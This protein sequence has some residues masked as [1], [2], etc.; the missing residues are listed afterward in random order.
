[1]MINSAQPTPYPGLRPFKETEALLFFGQDMALAELRERLYERKFVAILGLSGCGKSSL[2]RAGLLADIRPKK[3]EGSCSRWLIGEMQPGHDPL[4]NLI[5]TIAD[6]QRQIEAQTD[7]LVDSAGDQT[8]ALVGAQYRTSNRRRPL[9]GAASA[10]MFDIS[11]LCAD[12]YG[13]VRFGSQASLLRN[14]RVL[15]VVDQFEELFRFQREA[16]THQDKDRAALF[17]RLLIEAVRNPNSPVSVVIT[18]RS[19]FLGDC[20]LFFGLA[21]LVNEGTFL[22]PRISRGQ[23]EEVI[24]GP[25]EEC[26]FTVNP[27][28]I[29]IM[30]NEAEQQEDGLPLL[31]HALHRVWSRKRRDKSKISLKDFTYFDP[32]KPEEVPHIKHHL[33]DHL[34]RIYRSLGADRKDV[35]KLLFRMLYKYDKSGRL[36]RRPV[37]FPDIVKAIGKGREKDIIAVIE[38]FR[39][40]SL[41]RTFLTP[42]KP[43]PFEQATV[44]VSHECLLRRW[45]RLG[46][47]IQLEERDAEQFRRLAGDADQADL[48]A[49]QSKKP[50]QPLTGPNLERYTQWWGEAEL[51]SASWARR[52]QGPESALLGRP[53]RSFEAAKEYL[54]WSQNR[55]KAR[56]LYSVIGRVTAGCAVLLAA[57]VGPYMW[58]RSQAEREKAKAFQDTLLLQNEVAME[59]SRKDQQ[60]A[61]QQAAWNAKLLERNEKLSRTQAELNSK[62]WLLKATNEKLQVQNDQLTELTTAEAKARKKVQDQRDEL[63]AINDELKRAQQAERSEAMQ[64]AIEQQFQ[65]IAARVPEWSQVTPKW[66]QSAALANLSTLANLARQYSG[67]LGPNA[68]PALSNSFALTL[69]KEN[70]TGNG[71]PIIQA[72]AQENGSGIRIF[73]LGDEFKLPYRLPDGIFHNAAA[74]PTH[75]GYVVKGG[76]GGW[77]VFEQESPTTRWKRHFFPITALSYSTNGGWI[78]SASGAADLR[79]ISS[80]AVTVGYLP[81]RRRFWNV[82]KLS[83]NSTKLVADLFTYRYK[84]DYAVKDLA[85]SLPA[86][87]D[88]QGVPISRK[89]VTVYGITEGGQYLI[90][91]HPGPLGTQITS[92]TT[93]HPGNQWAQRTLQ[94]NKAAALSTE[95]LT[96]DV[97]LGY[98]DGGLANLTKDKPCERLSQS[99]GISSL[100]WDSGS[101]RLAIGLSTGKVRVYQRTGGKNECDLSFLLELPAHGSSVSSL[102]WQDDLLFTGSSD[103]T[104]RSWNLSLSESQLN[105]LALIRK[106]EILDSKA[107][108]EER[109]NL[110]HELLARLPEM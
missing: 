24:T 105:I 60:L 76:T 9:K 31:Q 19:E 47:W 88:S 6:L 10:P 7:A 42:P 108:P 92:V 102:F 34:D 41:G 32:P 4:A 71:S 1:M 36:T 101:K 35:T 94:N 53:E 39:D 80:S 104:A 73:S 33:D 8:E 28:V 11:D 93:E 61:S 13:L 18:M 22:L 57:V 106:G 74:N 45:D 85:I 75:P 54:E 5:T 27:D 46:R 99:R 51:I 63:T 72:L 14:Q 90:W 59:K 26:G 98:S 12:G 20:S 50:R 84:G 21:E 49:L 43:L 77:I 17:I 81:L 87:A 97:W 40:E 82:V 95:P 30:L 70:V 64:N 37:Y 44:D 65:A 16:P 91:Q 86:R 83:L 100:A 38:A 78:A 66:D 67:D 68:I 62:N 23:I 89:D 52:Y 96:Q 79:L 110:I 55:A 69:L 109:M 58:Y 107:K 103:G 48:T 25:A 2:L 3:I 29:Q 56:R 15:I